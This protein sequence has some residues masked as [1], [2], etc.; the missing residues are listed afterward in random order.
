M[1]KI[2]IINVCYFIKNV[3]KNILYQIQLFVDNY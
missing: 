1:Y 2:N 3:K